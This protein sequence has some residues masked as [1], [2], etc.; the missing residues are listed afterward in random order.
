LPANTGKIAIGARL[1]MAVPMLVLVLSARCAWAAPKAPADPI[2]LTIGGGAVESAAFRWSSA[3]AEI[4]SRP[5]G[6]PDCDPTGP[7][8]VPNVVAGAQTYDDAP[9][10][11][12]ALLDGRIATAVMPANPLFAARCAANPGMP[13]ASLRVLKILYRQ[14]LYIVVRGGSPEI[15]RPRDWAG[16]TVVTGI[17]GSDSALLAQALMESYGVPRGKLKVLRLPAAQAFAA[18]R[19][20]TVAIGVFLGHVNDRSIAGLIDKGFILMS[21]SDTPER[22]RLLDR[23]PVF[24][25]G[26]IPPGAYQGVPATS[27]LTQ[28]MVWVAGPSF[29]Q[30]LAGKLVADISEAHNTSRLAELVDPIPATPEAVAFRRLPVPL[31]DGVG[32]LAAREHA[33]VEVLPCPAPGGKS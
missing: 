1:S 30:G 16:K 18:M 28:P 23:L 10:L 3:L 19:A 7:C 29:D 2:Q 8:G 5:P 4:I 9:S 26:A 31:A 27:T 13:A 17:A 22:A 24:E 20:G 15:A 12:N 25:V 14:P 33:P 21:L 6:L 11:L 32:A